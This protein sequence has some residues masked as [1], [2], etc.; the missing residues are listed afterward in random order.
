[1]MSYNREY[2]NSLSENVSMSEN[3]VRAKIQVKIA[4]FNADFSM[5]DLF[6]TCI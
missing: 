6:V 4:V 3:D 2:I 1:M 5:A